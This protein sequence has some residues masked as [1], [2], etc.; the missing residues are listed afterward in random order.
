M[1]KM[2]HDN[3]KLLKMVFRLD[4]DFDKTKTESLFKLLED[5]YKN[6]GTLS[7]ICYALKKFF[8]FVVPD[9][10][11]SD[12]W[13]EKGAELTSILKQQ[14]MNG[15]LT[16][17]S[18]KK[19]WKTQKEILNIIKELSN[20]LKTITN[21][22]RYLLLNMCVFQPPL[23]RGV[24]S[25][26][27]FITDEKKNNK[28]DNYLML[29]PNPQKSYFIINKDKVSKYEKFNDPNNKKIEIISNELNELLNN[30]YNENKRDYV[31]ESSDGGPYEASNMTKILLAPLGLN[32]NILRSSYISNYYVKNPYPKEREELAKAMR[33]STNIAVNY[34]KRIK[35]NEDDAIDL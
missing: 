12:F 25:T 7:V 6:I 10:V 23:R 28:K 27:R 26:L 11:K 30:S 24:Y 9:K 21:K 35:K 34:V 32:F 29:K 18:E 4:N 33:H 22:N 19:N 20:N 17:E 2:T 1:E 31:F 8:D 14:E 5:K 16:G 3:K 15:E 13:S